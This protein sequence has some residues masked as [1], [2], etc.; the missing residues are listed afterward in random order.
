MNELL[1][2]SGQILVLVGALMGAGGGLRYFLEPALKRRHLRKVIAT[3]VWLSC[4]ELRCH[5]EEIKGKLER[6]S[7]G[8]TR[9][10]LM[11]IPRHDF[12]RPDWF[13]KW[14]YLSMI[15]AYK[16]AAFSSWMRIYQTA[17]LQALVYTTWSAFILELF[18]KFDSYKVAASRD[19]VLW[20]HYID[21]IGE[22]IIVN[23]GE[24]S[25][26]MGFSEFCKKYAEDKEFLFYFD[27]LHMFI[28]FMGVDDK[29]WSERYPRILT[30]MIHALQE[31]EDFMSSSKE[32]LLTKFQPKERSRSASAELSK[33]LGDQPQ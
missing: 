25:G 22:K 1:T 4:H 3:N 31:I 5:L 2:F 11:K 21:A 15:T 19:T 10:A 13:V 14:G 7:E 20:Y 16:I 6:K 18:Q 9:D 12:K 27:Q 23:V 24:T 8:G 33:Y 26:P 32:N 28:H 17:V 30:D 29:K